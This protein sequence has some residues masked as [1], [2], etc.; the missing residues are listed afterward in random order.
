MLVLCTICINV[1]AM[2]NFVK[3]MNKTDDSFKYFPPKY[4]GLSDPKKV[5]LLILRFMSFVKFYST[6]RD[7]GQN[8]WEALKL[9]AKI[10]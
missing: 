5:L 9:V 6:L 3:A 1:S 4:H 10:S 2:M 8:A 7:K